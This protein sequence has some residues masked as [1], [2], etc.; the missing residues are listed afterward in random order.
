MLNTAAAVT[1]AL[2]P[3]AGIT[4][5]AAPVVNTAITLTAASNVS[6]VSWQW[7]QISGPAT[8]SFGS[9]AAASTTFTVTSAGSYTIRLTITDA[10]GRTASADTSITVTPSVTPI[11]TPTPPPAPSSGGGGGGGATDLASLTGILALALFAAT[12]RNR[13]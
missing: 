10:I 13:A 1:L 5:S 12:R 8:G 6:P 9:P 4:V 2:E 3:T 7:S 11:P